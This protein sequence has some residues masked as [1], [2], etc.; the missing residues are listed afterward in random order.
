MLLSP[1]FSLH[2]LSV[3]SLTL[4][5]L[6][7]LDSCSS[8]NKLV[9]PASSATSPKLDSIPISDKVIKG[10]LE[11]GVSYLLRANNRPEDFAELRLIVK[12]GSIHEDE[13]QL[14]FAHFVEHMA[15]NGTADFKKREIIEFVES[16][17]MQFGAHLNAYTSFDETV[18]QLRIPLSQEG[19]LETGIH[20]LENWAHKISFE[21]QA[22]DDERGVVLEEW[23]S[24]LGAQE[25]IREQTMPILL[26]GS[27]YPD[28]LPIG[29]EHIIKQGKYEDLERYYKTWYR[30]DL[31]T[32]VVVGDFLTADSEALPDSRSDK[33]STSQVVNLIKKY[34]NQVEKPAALSEVSIRKMKDQKLEEYT[35]PAIK[36]VSDQDLSSGSFYVTWRQPK[37][38]VRNEAD[39]RQSIIQNLL[40]GSLNTRFNQAVWQAD[41]AFVHAGV[42][43]SRNYALGHQFTLG[44]SPK[45]NMLGNSLQSTLQ[46]LYGALQ[47]GISELEL[48]RQTKILL[49]GLHKSLSQEQTFSHGAYIEHLKAHAL[50]NEAIPS[51]QYYIET[52][53]RILPTIDVEDLQHQLKA[54]LNTQNA[55]MVA[56]LPDAELSKAPTEADLLAV[57]KGVGNKPAPIF[58]PPQD[59][60]ELMSE[61]DLSAGSVLN[62]SYVEKWDAHLWSLSNGVK[63]YLKPTEFKDNEIRFWAYSPGGYSKVDDEAYL[64]SFGMMDS[65]NNMGLG[66][67]GTDA[68]NQY[69]RDKRFRFS[70]KIDTYSETA[71]GSTTQQELLPFMQTMYLNFTAPRKDAEIFDWL[72]ELYAPKIEKRYNHPQNLFYAK[73]R[74]ATRAGNPRSVEFDSEMLSKQN[75]Q[76]IYQI[77]KQAFANAADFTFVFVGDMDLTSM[78]NMLSTYVATLPVSDKFDTVSLL[79]DYDAE[80]DIAIHLKK[81]TEPK[82]TVIMNMWGDAKWSAKDQLIYSGLISALEN[83][84]LIRLREE[85]GGVYGVNVGGSFSQ[86]PYQENNL[87]ISFTCKPER[88]EELKAEIEAVFKDFMTGNIS[89]ASLENYKTRLLSVRQ[90]QLKENGFWLNRLMSDVTPYQVVP[91]N[92]YNALVES[93][94]MDDLVKAAQQ[95]LNRSDKY[96][97]TLQPE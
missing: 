23:R 64:S 94:Q 30:A 42:S 28:R 83:R 89:Q 25:R 58:A 10:Q 22:I 88:I 9:E 1:L 66:N 17:G 90:K 37:F 36:I 52:V 60:L 76:T 97:A 44:V 24:R 56:T 2:K 26:K 74:Q 39:I 82:A 34:F 43:F 13:A 63:V 14:G 91:L 93:I 19:A 27:A 55:V 46:T 45:P 8:P 12:T 67:L 57:F 29:T 38:A 61:H 70:T 75:L 59:V 87:Q 84:L 21:H 7:L 71:Y 73:I 40:I 33:L 53:E 49:D 6:L 18:Y 69:S 32:V 62:K 16:I 78:E 85:L 20:I 54:W 72:K 5:L 77:R 68:Y 48:S 95:Y 31:M 51:L 3:F 50:Y 65:I 92:E 41:T 80:G 47:H 4:L 15:F 11:N 79:P 35:E 81:G 96:F 86:W